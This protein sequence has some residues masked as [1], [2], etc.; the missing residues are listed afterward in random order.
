M[1][2]V[3]VSATLVLMLNGDEK[4]K[5]IDKGYIGVGYSEQRASRM[6][7][8]VVVLVLVGGCVGGWNGWWWSGSRS[9]SEICNCE[10]PLKRYL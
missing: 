10:W 6:R 3:G 8:L 1:G 7:L 2:V 5:R 9:R 4:N